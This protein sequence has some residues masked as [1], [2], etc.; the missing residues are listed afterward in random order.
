MT[1]QVPESFEEFLRLPANRSY[2]VLVE[3]VRAFM[4]DHVELNRL[5]EDFES[6]DRDLFLGITMAIDDINSTPPMLTKSLDQMMASGWGSLLVIGSVLNVLRSVTLVYIRNN[7]SFND[8]GLMTGGLSA[9]APEIQDWI[10]R[11]EGRY[12]NLKQKVKV[13][14]NLSEMMGGGP[15]GLPSEYTLVHGLAR[16]WW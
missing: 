9:K 10:A 4:R 3:R 13:A 11:N 2:A 14:A 1:D 6:S 15:L 7:L 8:G 16:Y 5:V 12:E